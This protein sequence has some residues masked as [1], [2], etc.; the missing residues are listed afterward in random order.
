MESH[1]FDFTAAM[2]RLCADMIARLAELQHID[3]GRVAM[4]LSQTRKSVAYG[5]Y[6]SLTP[7][8]FEGGA[9]QKEL[10]GRH[11]GVDPMRDDSGREYLY[12][13]SF[14]LPRFANTTWEEKLSTVLHE[15]WHISP[16]FNGDLRRHEGRCYAHGRSQREYDARM[17]RLAQKWLALGPPEPLY[18]FLLKS[19][20]ELVAEHG[21]VKGTHWQTPKLVQM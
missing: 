15:L 12:I 2:R 17:D 8:R 13:L 1:G 6:A 4:S 5:L 14:Y 11:Y 10:R 7:L 21:T 16:E 3:L 20:E 19:F 9:L 18:D